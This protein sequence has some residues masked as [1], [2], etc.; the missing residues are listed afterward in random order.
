M[1]TLV[2]GAVGFIGR[3]VC[4]VMSHNGDVTVGARTPEHG[5]GKP[6]EITHDTAAEQEHQR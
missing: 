6:A 3:T 5:G 1:K 2:I 4:R